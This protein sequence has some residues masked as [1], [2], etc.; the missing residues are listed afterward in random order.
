MASINVP[1]VILGGL[2]AGLVMN[3][4]DVTTGLTILADDMN[5][6][7]QRLNLDPAV[8]NSTAAMVT[9]IIVDFLYGL[10]VV[11][12]YAGFRPRFGPGPKTAIIAGL[13]I[14]AAIT[15]ILAGFLAVGMFMQD[16]FIKQAAIALVVNIVASLVGGAIYK[17]T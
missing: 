16:V 1:R 12:T 3:V 6:N 5:A 4:L 7:A 9:W 15:V 8:L 2:A 10:L 13:T 14:Y 17:E 11:F